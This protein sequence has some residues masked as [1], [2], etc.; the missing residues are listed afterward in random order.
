MYLIFEL[1][2]KC[3][4]GMASAWLGLCEVYFYF[5]RLSIAVTGHGTSTCDLPANHET[6]Q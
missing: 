5:I 2:Y 4:H 6:G 3:L 1:L